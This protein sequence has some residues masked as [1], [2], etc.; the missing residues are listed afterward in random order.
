MQKVHCKLILHSKAGHLNQIYTGFSQ[1]EKQGYLTLTKE[2]NFDTNKQILEVIINN[3]IKI[4]YDTMDEEEFY[5]VDVMKIKNIDYYFKRSFKK[6]VANKYEFKSFPL[7]LNY[8]V[9]SEYRNILGLQDRIKN[10]IKKFIRKDKYNFYSRDFEKAPIPSN[11]P[12]IC[13]LTRVWD[14]NG[15]EIENENVRKE[16]DEI[17]KFR[18]ECIRACKKAFGDNFIGGIEDS[19]FA[20]EYYSDVIIKDKFITKRDNFL[21]LIKEC[22]ICIATTGLHKSIGWKFGEYI[23]ASRAIVTEPLCYELPG[24]IEKDRNYIEFNNVNQL[25]NILKEL[26]TNKEKRKSLMEN[27]YDYYNCFVKPDKL[28]KNSLEKIIMKE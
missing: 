21:D 5:A 24:N 26:M 13:F 16:R 2:N 6:E 3:N 9:Y 12:K 7:G 10:K 1:L 8:N 28:I 18:V 11:N 25:I 23:A 27:N 17:N 4:I 20:R 19:E 15:K 14:I 22:D